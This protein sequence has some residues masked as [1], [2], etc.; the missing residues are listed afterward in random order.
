MYSRMDRCGFARG[1][2]RG[3]FTLIELLTV[4]AIIGLLV[5]MVVPTIRS[6]I[7]A[8][9][10]VRT[11][12]RINNLS[13]GAQM[14][15]TAETGNKYYPGQQYLRE[16]I[17]GTYSGRASVFLAR[18][19]FTKWDSTKDPKPFPISGYSQ[20]DEEMLDDPE[21]TETGE[22]YAI[23]DGHSN[24]LAI[25]YFVSKAKF[26]DSLRGKPEQFDQSHNSRFYGDGGENIAADGDIGRFARYSGEEDGQDAIIRNEGQF[27]L[28]APGR[29]RLYF[30]GDDKH[31]S[32]E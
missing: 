18:C 29:D 10:D 25:L 2:R 26:D 20:Y 3:A 32:V 5:S 15:K 16:Q 27:L 13:T 11:K 31:N 24:A 22:P 1:P 4:V 14:Y 12:V 23:L 21:G 9:T 8:Q 7:Q 19:L 28:I 30:N 17:E 6:V